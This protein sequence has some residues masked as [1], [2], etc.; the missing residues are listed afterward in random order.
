MSRLDASSG[1]GSVF[2]ATGNAQSN[3]D[4]L[5]DLDKGLHKG[6]AAMLIMAPGTVHF[7]GHTAMPEHY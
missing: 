1:I 5:I 6:I 7:I 3:T 2:S 4:T